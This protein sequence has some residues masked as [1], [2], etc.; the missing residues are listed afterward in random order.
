MIK[1][2][3]IIKR[4]SHYIKIENF[5]WI[6]RD[7]FHRSRRGIRNTKINQI[8]EENNNAIKFKDA[9]F[10]LTFGSRLI[11]NRDNVLEKKCWNLLKKILQTQSFLN[12]ES[13]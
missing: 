7:A 13:R 11:G 9:L 12:L 4:F 10:V 5:F 8:I 6:L 2:K 3:R 1:I